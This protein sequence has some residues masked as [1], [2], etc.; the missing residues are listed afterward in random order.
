MFI[1]DRLFIYNPSIPGDI[2]F[3]VK[4]IEKSEGL[5]ERWVL[6]KM[7]MDEFKKLSN[8]IENYKDQGD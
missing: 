8:L 2:I 4:D 1:N 5:S 6:C 7:T 3:T